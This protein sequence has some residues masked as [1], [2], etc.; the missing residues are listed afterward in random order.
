[1]W[2]RIIFWCLFVLWILD[3]LQPGY[4]RFYDARSVLSNVAAVAMKSKVVNSPRANTIKSAPRNNND[5][6]IDID[7]ACPAPTNDFERLA[8]IQ[9]IGCESVGGVGFRPRSR[10]N[11]GGTPARRCSPPN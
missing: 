7:A 9:A 4:M 1:M 6:Y 2:S 8:R 5:E 11:G 3:I 10:L